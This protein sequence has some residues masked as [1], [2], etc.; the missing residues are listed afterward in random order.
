MRPELYWI[1]SI[2]RGRL[3][4]APRPRGGEWLSGEFAQWQRAGLDVVVSLLT[5]EEVSELRL[6]RE[7]TQAKENGLLFLRLPIKDR[8]IP[9]SRAEAKGLIATITNLLREGKGVC[10]HCRMGIG[11]SALIAAGVLLGLGNDVAAAF[12]LVENAR[13]MKVPDT[14]EQVEWVQGLFVK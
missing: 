9:E 1:E 11:R 4:I 7:E 6:Q 10:V 13:K 8:C 14:D 12:R 5:D 2:D 3:A